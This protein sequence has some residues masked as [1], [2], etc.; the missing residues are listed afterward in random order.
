MGDN[1]L[2]T[3]PGILLCALLALAVW[4]DVRARRIPNLLV[5]PGAM[6]GVL[7]NGCLAPGAG[8]FSAPFGGLGWLA[9]LGGLAVGLGLLLPMYLLRAMGAGD[10]K[11]LAMLGAF[12]GPQAVLGAALLCLLAGG[13]LALSVA[14]WTGQLRQI[15]GNTYHMMLH[16]LLRGLAGET[17][18]VAAPAAPSGKL[19]YAIAIAV[20][21]LPYI[22]LAR[23]H[24]AGL[25]P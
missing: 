24:G 22:V 21:A 6:V 25:L 11:L 14:C 9:A 1:F 19:P 4:H 13:V 18:T 23:S 15:L 3:A 20:G 16:S 17:P 12:L 7:L 5:F 2:I 8:L 10:V